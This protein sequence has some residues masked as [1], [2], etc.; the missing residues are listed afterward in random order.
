M[1]G[2]LALLNTFF[3]FLMIQYPATAI[4][5][6]NWKIKCSI[7]K[8]DLHLLVVQML[9]IFVYVCDLMQWMQ[10]CIHEL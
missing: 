1:G 9:G 3:R 6:G 5:T 2:S 10:E 8:S 7:F 4:G